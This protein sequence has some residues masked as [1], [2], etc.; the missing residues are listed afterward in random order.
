MVEISGEIPREHQRLAVEA[1]AWGPA[2]PTLVEL[3]QDGAVLASLREPPYRVSWPLTEGTHVF[4][5]AASD[6]EGN[7]VMSES[8]KVSVLP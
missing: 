7:R 2:R 8:V 4:Q 6:D 1:L 3:Y 5:A